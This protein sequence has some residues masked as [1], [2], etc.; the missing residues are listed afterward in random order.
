MVDNFKGTESKVVFQ[1]LRFVEVQRVGKGDQLIYECQPCDIPYRYN[2][3][4]VLPG[5]R[6]RRKISMT[7]LD[8]SCSR[9]YVRSSP[10][11]D[12]AIRRAI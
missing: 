8:I 11:G 9:P 1:W 12:E 5:A 3:V 2:T 7:N 10:Q 6:S 4:K